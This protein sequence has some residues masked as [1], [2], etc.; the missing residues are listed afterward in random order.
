MPP[1]SKRLASL[2]PEQ[3]VKLLQQLKAT[4]KTS[5]RYQ[6]PSRATPQSVFPLSFT[7]QRLWFLNQLEPDNPFYNIPALFRL[8]GSL[9]VAAL[10][11]SLNAIARRHECLR[12]YFQLD[13]DNQPVQIVLPEL[14]VPLTVQNLQSYPEPERESQALQVALQ[15][16]QTPFNLSS[17][18]LWRASVLQ[19]QPQECLLVLTMHH[20]IF[21]GWALGVFI[22]ELAHL[23]EAYSQERS[24]SLD[25]LRIQ[26]AD[27]AVWQ[28]QWFQDE[29][30]EQQLNYW[31]SQLAGKLPI[32]ELPCDRPR[33]R[34]QTFEGSL[35]SLLLSYSLYDDLKRISREHQVTLFMTTLT[36]FYILL[37]RYTNET[38]LIVGFP[39]SGRNLREVDDL[40]GPCVNTLALRSD[41]SGDPSFRELLAKVRQV[42]LDSY[43]YQDL[44]FDLL[45]ETIQPERNPSYNPVFQVMFTLQN[46]LRDIETESLLFSYEGIDMG[47]SKF[48]LSLDVF[49]G[50]EGP[51]CVFEYNSALFDADRIVRMGHH[52]KTLL[53]DV[54]AHPDR[55][56]SQLQLLDSPEQQQI[57]QGWNQT[58]AQFPV[59]A[60]Q[61]F[62]EAQ[63]QKTPEAIA[64]RC[65]SETLTYQALNRRANRLARILQAQGVKPDT[66]VPILAE[67]GLL[68]LIGILAI[69]KAGGAYLP[70]DPHHPSQRLSQVIGQ[71]Q[72]STNQLSETLVGMPTPAGEA[73][74]VIAARNQANLLE[75][76]CAQFD[77]EQCPQFLYLEDLLEQDYDDH[78]LPLAVTPQH[79]AYVIFTSGSTGVPKGAMIEQAGMLNHLQVMNQVLELGSE[80]VVA[81]TASQCFD[82][83]VWQYLSALMVG[84][85][86]QIIPDEEVRDPIALLDQLQAHGISVLEIVPSLLQALINELEVSPQANPNGTDRSAQW[87]LTSLRWLIPTGETLPPEL[88]RRWLTLHPHIPMLNAYGPAECSDDVTLYAITTP[89]PE[90]WH[91]IPIG[92]PVA[93]MQIYVLDQYQQPVPVGIGGEIYIGGIG[94]GR[95]YLNDPERTA[96]A[97][98]DNP[99]SDGQGQRLY[100]TGDLG[101]YQADG[102][103]VFLGR[104][105]HQVKVRGFRI[106]LGEI[107]SVL[108]R[109]S[110]VE[111]AA[112][113]IWEQ[114]QNNP[115]IVAYVVPRSAHI[116][117]SDLTAFL[118]EH[119]PDYMIP[120]SILTLKEMPLSQNGK[121][122]R[123][124]LPQ[125]EWGT[126]DLLDANYVGPRTSTEEILTEIWAQAFNLGRVSIYDDFFN[127]GGHSL[128]A[129]QIMSQIRQSFQVDLPLRNFFSTPTVA[130]LAGIIAEQQG[131]QEDYED[132]INALPQMEPDRV[133]WYQ[134]FPLTD[135]QEAYWIGR[136]ADFEL[137]NV[138][139][140]NYD[141][142]IFENLDL[143][144]FDRAWQ[145]LIQRHGMLRAIVHPDGRQEIL[146]TVP[147]YQIPVFDLRG[148]SEA[149]I[150][151]AITALRDEMNHQILDTSQ[152][153]VFDLRISLHNEGIARLHV[154]TDSLTFDAWSFVVL[155]RELVTL[156]QQPDTV[157][158]PLNFSFRDYVLAEQSLRDSE[159]YQ[160]SLQYWQNIIPYLPPAPELPLIKNP[161]A[162][163][164]PHF[165]RLHNSLD[166]GTWKRL[167][168]KATARG[169]TATGILLAAYAETLTAWSKSPAFTLNLTF[170]NRLPFHPQV[171][172]LVGEFTSLT[173]LGVDQNLYTSFSE[174]AKT[175]QQRLWSDL[176]NHYVSGIQVLRELKR[177]QG[178]G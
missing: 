127:L 48:D 26:Y 22:R 147:A 162:V 139:T 55:P 50:P 30:R 122:N 68:F 31:K 118:K 59:G 61:T 111:A 168:S 128:L 161:S 77:G 96:Q 116:T 28:R 5:P 51:N 90:D 37:H 29:I 117:A 132:F 1:I 103:L 146:E 79:L 102:T 133:N 44:P 36:V 60:F 81:Q 58:Q 131:Q 23:Y 70:L 87:D 134:P 157:L 158:P 125:P 94:V 173:L 176:E 85:C 175:I 129:I 138:S 163:E 19:L 143:Q 82:I 43:N 76:T 165:T 124:A 33:P 126:I 71:C 174:R 21:D 159:H 40:I 155:M 32:L 177:R 8:T 93:N 145:T 69:L 99:F 75:S 169:L 42:T 38:D 136:S 140:H 166:S 4:Q 152:W 121:I 104:S 130:G 54:V 10:E 3:R 49:E 113:E 64:A 46:S 20:T 107:E 78:D 144:R 114:G 97:F 17:P 123:T 156:H 142:L 13:E 52:Y 88:C 98:L 110:H 34:I 35:H 80:D 148:H 6:I 137:G 91:Q 164:R 72:M 95:G 109:H 119:L 7:Q 27:Y 89:P 41:L 47:S 154:S 153:P 120:A 100:R 14:S 84:G 86:V 101:R 150:D 149:E 63:V 170:L 92:R 24:P 45:V 108:S 115:Q 57:L 172:D 16:F 167:K 18:P 66:I 135:V 25:E 105:D 62:F 56:I 53:Q 9:Q 83:S 160:R 2:S 106:E 15:E 112:V 11:S 74:L 67:R 73:N 12:T 178:G 65:G 141:E 151:M 39:I 171:N